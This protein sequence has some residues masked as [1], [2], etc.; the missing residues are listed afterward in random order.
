MNPNPSAAPNYWRDP[1]DE[2]AARR[3]IGV[4]AFDHA[5]AAGYAFCMWMRSGAWNACDP[6]HF[7]A[8]ACAAELA[9]VVRAAA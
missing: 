7:A 2:A 8:Y 4:D 5:V 6:E 1:M 9:A 3:A